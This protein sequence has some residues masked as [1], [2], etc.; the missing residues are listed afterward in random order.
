MGREM[1]KFLSKNSIRIDW[2][3]A[4][5]FHYCNNKATLFPLVNQLRKMKVVMIGPAHLRAVDERLFPYAHFIEIPAKN[6]YLSVDEIQKQLLDIYDKSGPAVFAF[7][8]SMTTNVLIQ[9]LYPVMGK[10]SWMIDFGSLWDV[11]VG[12]HS[13]GG[14]AKEDWTERMNKNC[15][16]SL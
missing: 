13:R 2:Q 14:Y 15:G 16:V 1:K 8:A 5:V 12:V 9:K 7:S 11:Y 10:T 4:D 3:D 6:C